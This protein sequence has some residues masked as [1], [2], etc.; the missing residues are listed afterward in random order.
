MS[1]SQQSSRNSSYSTTATA[2][3]RYMTV[4]QIEDDDLTFGGKPLSD[5]HEDHRYRYSSTTNA[6][7]DDEL[8]GRTRQRPHEIASSSGGSHKHG[9]KHHSKKSDKK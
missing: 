4:I 8:R 2:S 7:S 3:Y 1:S 9:H 6:S 5:W